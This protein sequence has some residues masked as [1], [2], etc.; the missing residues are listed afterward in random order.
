M[1]RPLVS[2]LVAAYEEERHIAGCLASLQRQ[3]WRPL[4]ILVADDGSRDRTAEIARDAGVRVLRLPHGGKARALNA[5]ATE[6]RG[7][8]LVFCDADLQYAADYVERLVGPILSGSALGTSH[9]DESVANP[10]N[11]W[12]RCM[13]RAHGLPEDLRL[14]LTLE[15][16]REG[17]VVFRAI[18]RT[19]F[20][21]V[22]GFDE[23]GYL[24]DQSLAPKLAARAAF[25]DGAHCSHHNPETLREI[26]RM[27]IWSGKSVY[28]LQGARGL[29][30][31]APPRVLWRAVV[32]G[33]RHRMVAMVPYT[34]AL[35]LGIF[36]GVMRRVLGDPSRGA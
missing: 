7:E 35:E 10:E 9:A 12:S 33:M 29:I 1:T 15:Q 25:V 2:A 5:A 4:E 14:N 8:V 36:W 6:A 22:G 30:S 19:D 13:Q 18:R 3:T 16:R 34:L 23:T 20:I 17:T 27:G 24:D 32:A 31:F 11:I 21:S 26:A 28:H